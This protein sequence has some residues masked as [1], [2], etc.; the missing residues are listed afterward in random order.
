L[1]DRP[2]AQ[3]LEG[4]DTS[5]FRTVVEHAADG[6]ILIDAAERIWLFNP[7]CERLFGYSAAEVI[8]KNVTLLM[9]ARD[10][11]GR[12]RSLDNFTSIGIGQ[13]KDGSTFSMDLSVGRTKR[14]GEPVFVGIIR[15]LTQRPRA[16]QAMRDSEHNYRALVDGVTDY[17]IYMLDLTG[18]VT[19]WNT[20][21]QRLKQFTAGEI[22]GRHF[23]EF[24][25]EEEIRRGE[26]ERN[27]GIVEREGRFEANAWRRRKDGS[28]F[29][30]N[31]VIEPLKNE[32][33]HLIGFAKVTSDITERRRAEQVIRE[34][35]ERINAIIETIVDGVILIGKLGKIQTFN[36]ACQKLFGYRSEEV[37]GQNVKMLMPPH[38]RDEHDSYLG[39]YHKTGV[40]KIIGIGREVV[41]QRKD[42]STFPM[43]LSVGEA[44]QDG[45][46]I[47]VGIIH[48]LS[49][50][51]RTEEQLVQ[52]QKMEMV[53][54]LSGGIAHD[55]NN[56]LTV[57]VGNSEFLGEQLGARQDLKQLA[58]D[59][60]RAGERGAELTQRLLAFS[61]RQM[62]RPVAIDCNHLLDSMRKLLR[63]TLREDIE[64]KTDPDLISAFADPAQ[65]E[66]AVLN[67]A[68]NAQDAMVAGG[69]LT[70]ITT[71]ASLDDHYQSLHPEILPGEYVLVSVTDDGEGM[72]KEIVQRV[73]EP[74]Y[75]TKEVGK[76][77]GLGLS[78]VYGF[79][80]QSNG[81]VS[82]HSAPGL[83]TTVRMYLEDDPFVRSFVAMRL[84]SLGYSVVAAIDGNDALRKLRTD[85]HIDILFTDIVMPG[86]IN[87]WE[88]ADLAK[89]IRPGLP[90]L[91]TSGYALE[92]LVQQGRLEAGAMVLAKPYR[93][94]ALARRLREIVLVGSLSSSSARPLAPQ[95]TQV[96]RAKQ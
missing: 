75:T 94:D 25:T 12:D 70:L 48:D 84:E 42:G 52:A 56:L 64:I 51:K 54:Q 78:M 2:E 15:D 92:T 79:T 85:I 9:P 59:I 44:K 21:A 33:G 30:A 38:Y 7:A 55:F 91:L 36:P 32:H 50:R 81:H 40:R 80:K 45:E 4:A 68:L 11:F 82:I 26:P 67:L 24:Y 34:A 93:R 6:V 14:D 76:G 22:L 3:V 95:A 41:G 37:I 69:R 16:G 60:G 46:T 90:V 23:R 65:L 47:F 1:S 31:L 13:R 5:L 73:F 28:Q 62:L 77:S 53:G 43:L 96:E 20:G 87:G 27:L 74:F 88:F 10:H 8:G 29:W 57:I 19:T 63:R 35:G 18:H 17:A 61:R 58:D 49:E 71:N 89:Q 39:N 66:S 72:P 86:G 83:G